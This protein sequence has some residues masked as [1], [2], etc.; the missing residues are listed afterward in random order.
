MA[1]SRRRLFQSLVLTGGCSTASEGAEPAIGLD[2]L[3]HVTA[4]HG[5]NL[6]DDRLRLI[7]AV[8]EQR[9]SELH[10]IRDFEVNDSIAPTAGILDK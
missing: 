4:A 7:K 9:L 2:M 10:A 6:S 1:L 8:V 5:T 3:R